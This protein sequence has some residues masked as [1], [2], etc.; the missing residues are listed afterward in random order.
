MLD[1][2]EGHTDESVDYLE[3][4]RANLDAL[5]AGLVCEGGP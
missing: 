2:L 1:P 5:R 4:M 3:V